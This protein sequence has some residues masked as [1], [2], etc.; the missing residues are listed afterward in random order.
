ML[1]EPLLV[2]TGQ[3]LLSR[4]H[5]GILC[6]TLQ[7]VFSAIGTSALKWAS[8]HA[9]LSALCVGYVLHMSALALYPLALSYLPMRT[10]VV[11][12]TAVANTNAVIAGQMLFGE[13]VTSQRLA[14]CVLNVVG[15]V[16][17]VL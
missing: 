11:V 17:T 14:G 12:W 5:W 7:V 13:V 3:S 9:S 16:L 8:V 1:T 2:Q 4:E 15:V 6:L 10:V